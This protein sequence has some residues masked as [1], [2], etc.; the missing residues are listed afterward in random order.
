[1]LL[2][3][4]FNMAVHCFYGV[5]KTG[6]IELIVYSGN[7]T[8]LVLALLTCHEVPWRTAGRVFLGALVLLIGLNNYFVFQHI[9]AIY[10]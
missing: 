1:M 9:V 3:V 4:V 8:F 2:C 7:F 10:R 5:G 6:I